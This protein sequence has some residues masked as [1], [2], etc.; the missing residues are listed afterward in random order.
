M[1]R[2][3]YLDEKICKKEEFWDGAR[4]FIALF[5]REEKDA[6]FLCSLIRKSYA[7]FNH[8]FLATYIYKKVHKK[9]LSIEC[10]PQDKHGFFVSFAKKE[11]PKA[12]MDNAPL[13]FIVALV[14]S[15]KVIEDVVY[16]NLGWSEICK[17]SHSKISQGEKYVLNLLGWDVIPQDE[18]F[19]SLIHSFEALSGNTVS[20]ISGRRLVP[21]RRLQRYLCS[22]LRCFGS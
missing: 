5:V 2:L 4:K 17:I 20:F 14:I 13:V 18:E 21:K 7:S 9:N 8:F 3:Y 6:D 16:S 11:S 19:A 12:F 10:E 15:S 1:G 22:L